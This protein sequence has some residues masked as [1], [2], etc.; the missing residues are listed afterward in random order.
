M[1]ALRTIIVGVE[2]AEQAKD[3]VA[4]AHEIA[5]AAGGEILLA[6]AVPY[7]DGPLPTEYLAVQH[8]LVA[9]AEVRLDRLADA[10]DPTV[11][12][13]TLARASSSP[14]H[15]LHDLAEEER[16]ALVVVGPTH[17]GKLE[18]VIPGRTAERLTHGAPCAVIT[19]PARAAAGPI[20]RVGV[21]YDASTESRAAVDAGAKEDDQ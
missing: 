15:L 12:V 13:R 2:D 20:K 3:Q 6:T 9:D 16:A 7:A 21:A 19:T 8:A 14:A 17:A 1:I 18:R 5:T 11:P 10:L 4:L